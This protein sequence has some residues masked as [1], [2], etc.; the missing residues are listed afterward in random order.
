MRRTQ[1]DEM[2]YHVLLADYLSTPKTP[3]QLIT[4]DTA[5]HG[6]KQHELCLTLYYSSNTKK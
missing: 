1:D 5:N 4:Y 3:P 2:I 6:Q